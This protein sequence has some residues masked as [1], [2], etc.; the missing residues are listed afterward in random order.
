MPEKDEKPEESTTVEEPVD[1][2]NSESRMNFLKGQLNDMLDS[3]NNVY[4]QD[5]MDE[6]LKRLE[7]T[8]EDF[9]GEVSGLIGKL[10]LGKIFEEDDPV[11]SA[12]NSTSSAEDA[13]DSDHEEEKSFEEQEEEDS[14]IVARMRKR[15]THD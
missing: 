3:I 12:A 10:K 13:L 1:F 4:G 7:K 14:D 2:D 6:L 8:V 11:E 5:L 15:I 9:N